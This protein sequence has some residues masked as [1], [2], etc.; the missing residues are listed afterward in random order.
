M[1]VREAASR[2]VAALALAEVDKSDGRGGVRADGAAAT[3]LALNSAERDDDDDADNVVIGSGADVAAI[4]IELGIE[5]V[6]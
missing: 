5:D 1:D 2:A 3:R 4:G 6:D